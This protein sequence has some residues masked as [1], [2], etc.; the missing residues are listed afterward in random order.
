M[1]VVPLRPMLS[2]TADMA[3]LKLPA[4]GSPKIDGHR[5][6]VLDMESGIAPRQA[7]RPCSRGSDGT[8]PG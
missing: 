7:H 2:A 6:M 5:C 3:K 4:Y 1:K 8:A